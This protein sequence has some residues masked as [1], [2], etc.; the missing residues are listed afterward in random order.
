MGMNS[1]GV[2]G[3]YTSCCGTELR[4]AVMRCMLAAGVGVSE[5]GTMGGA[6]TRV[7]CYGN[8]YVLFHHMCNRGG[9]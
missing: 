2:G 1:W 5:Y 9:C 8:C 4:F 3:M 6:G 7:H